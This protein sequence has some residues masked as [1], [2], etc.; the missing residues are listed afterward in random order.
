MLLKEN[1][2]LKQEILRLK[3]YFASKEENYQKEISGINK[4]RYEDIK[5]LNEKFNR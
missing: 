1:E 4:K 3:E 5:D 2:K